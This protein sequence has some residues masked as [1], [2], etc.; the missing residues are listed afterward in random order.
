MNVVVTL[1]GIALGLGFGSLVCSAAPSKRTLKTHDVVIDKELLIT[2]QEVVDSPLAQYPGPWSFGHLMNEA[3]GEDRAPALVAKW[4]TDWTQGKQADGNQPLGGL[5]GFGGFGGRQPD[6]ADIPDR[7]GV[8]KKLIRTWQEADGFDPTSG[9]E[10]APNF[11]NA[12]FQLLGIVNR[13]DLSV[14]LLAFDDP[15]NIPFPS[16]P[17]YYSSGSGDSSGG[18]GRLIFAVTDQKG[19]PLEPGTTIILEYGLDIARKQ[20]QF[21]DWATAWHELGTYQSHGSDYRAALAKVTRLF[22]DQRDNARNGKLEAEQIAE[23]PLLERIRSRATPASSQLLRVRINDGA[24]GEVREFREFTWSAEGLAAAPLAGTPREVFFRRG[25]SE[26]RWMARWLRNQLSEKQTQSTA[27]DDIG[28]KM[29]NNFIIPVSTRLRGK[30][31]PVVA[32][33]A[34]VPENNVAYHWDGWGLKGD[35][36]RR[37]FSMQTCCGCHCGDTN[38]AFFHLAPRKTGEATVLSKYLRTD[39]TRWRPIDPDSKRSYLSSEMGFR[40]ELFEA[41]LTPDMRPSEL[42]E[43]REKRRG[44]RKAH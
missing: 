13:M 2:A 10:W 37:A 16:G 18:E 27:R 11:E 29:P 36:L 21:L 4:L 26:N 32:H 17:A 6:P 8:R 25:T 38:T 34:P 42:E 3:F 15:S 44:R 23:M 12:P 30:D 28:S 9:K 20:D 35:D 14:P 24:F 7:E 33:V 1:G 41:A 31:V 19:V 40:K 5:G 39:G 43:I 22:T